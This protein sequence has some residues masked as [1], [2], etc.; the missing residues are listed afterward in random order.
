WQADHP[1]I[2]LILG[3]V[4][5]R[6]TLSCY[7]N[8]S[9]LTILRTIQTMPLSE[10]RYFLPLLAAVLR[11]IERFILPRR[12]RQEYLRPAGNSTAGSL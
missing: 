9:L 11:S 8:I 4:I 7:K 10:E 1:L 12:A 5:S 3:R 6:V 2:L